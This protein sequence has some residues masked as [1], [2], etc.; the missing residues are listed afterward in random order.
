MKKQKPSIAQSLKPIYNTSATHACL[1][2]V[3]EN[4]RIGMEK[5]HLSKDTH[6]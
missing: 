3:T 1:I 2:N 5:I 6:L 4:H